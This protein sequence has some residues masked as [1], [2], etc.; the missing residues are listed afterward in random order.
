MFPAMS[1]PPCT[2]A[3]AP[4]GRDPLHHRGR[5]A[6]ARAA[7]AFA[8]AAALA[9]ALAVVVGPTAPA[10]ASASTPSTITRGQSIGYHG[11]VPAL[12]N[13]ATAGRSLRFTVQ[14][15]GNAVTYVA[16]RSRYQS[17]TRGADASLHL[18]T[19]GNLVLYSGQRV[20]KSW[21]LTGAARLS[22]QTD[23]NLVVYST[24]GRPLWATGPKAAPA[25]PAATPGTEQIADGLLTML[26]GERHAHGLPALKMNNQLITSAKAHN[27]DM[28]AHD[29]MSH[30]LPGEPFFAVRI[31]R[32]GFNYLFA[33]ENIGWNTDKTLP[34]AQYLENL[35]YH[36]TP[37]NDGHR[38]NI[39]SRNYTDVGIH[40]YIDAAH[41]K[42][43][44]TQDF[45]RPQ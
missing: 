40:L 13:T 45:G 8:T 1:P 39:L 19:D 4:P 29:T 30:Q 5:S 28:A 42:M 32:A 33:G 27:L 43:W 24:S 22:L 18:Q 41:D 15:D 12:T 31:L 36:E 9:V 34:G 17:G 25:A 20:A 6:C 11:T 21:Q 14:S 26:N 44:L 23:G 38:Q 37:P 16:A 7:S 2:Q 35:M 10:G 3:V